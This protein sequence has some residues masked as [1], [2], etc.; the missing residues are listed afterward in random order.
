LVV[1]RGEVVTAHSF[2]VVVWVSVT[3]E[4]W[5]ELPPGT[6]R[7]PAIL[8]TGHS[9][10]FSIPDRQLRLWA[11]IVPP[12]LPLL[13]NVRINRVNVPLRAASLW[14]HPNRSGQR[15]RF[16]ASPPFRL[17]LPRGIAIYPP[18]T[19]GEPRL[20]LLGLRALVLNNLH[21]TIDGQNRRVTL[22]TLR[23][24]WLF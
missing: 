3:P 1:N 19:P 8:D 10:N 9:H 4:D 16:T 14:L 2:Q 21:L 7:L 23:R 17:Q 20:P 6:P 22:R 24:F 15:D 18:D 5:T 13:R 11:G 12:A